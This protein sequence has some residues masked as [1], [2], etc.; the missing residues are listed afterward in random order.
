MWQAALERPRYHKAN[1][2]YESALDAAKECAPK[3]FRLRGVQV[4]FGIFICA[5]LIHAWP[6]LALPGVR[7]FVMPLSWSNEMA[8][9][10]PLGW[11]QAMSTKLGVLL[12]ANTRSNSTS[13]SGIFAA[14]EA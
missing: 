9:M 6:I 2:W 8:Q 14:G 7:H 10:Q 11:Q 1:L 12:A 3:S 5:D 13:G 4:P